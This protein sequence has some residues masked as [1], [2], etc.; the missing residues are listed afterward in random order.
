MTTPK[1]KIS[2]A[3]KFAWEVALYVTVGVIMSVIGAAW[4]WIPAAYGTVTSIG[5]NSEGI[6]TNKTAIIEITETLGGM[7][8]LF[9]NAEIQEGGLTLTASVNTDSDARRWAAQG[10]R[11]QVINIG[12]RRK[13]S[14]IVTVEGKFEDDPSIFLFLSRASGSAIGAAPGEKVVVSI[15]APPENNAN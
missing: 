5:T 1:E 11:L 4:W 12:D 14:A 6:A 3:R 8:V 15:E 7:G 2:K 9:G 13:M 10:T